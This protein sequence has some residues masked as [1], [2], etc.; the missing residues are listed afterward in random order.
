MKQEI[1]DEE[2]R[3]DYMEQEVEIGED[4][5][6]FFNDLDNGALLE[7]KGESFEGGDTGVGE[8]KRW[9]S[10]SSNAM[11]FGSQITIDMANL[12]TFNSSVTAPKQ[13]ENSEKETEC[14]A[15]KD[16]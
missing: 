9:D 14:D 8:A 6:A 12:I 2:E 4:E 10:F 15:K 16:K 7:G 3:D 13:G 1:I 11:V 5:D